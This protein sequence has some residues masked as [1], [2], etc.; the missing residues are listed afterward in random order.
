MG[1]NP[2]L[3]SQLLNELYSGESP[4]A[5]RAPAGTASHT[6]I[7]KGRGA[8]RWTRH[9]PGYTVVRTR[10]RPPHRVAAAT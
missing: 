2:T 9:A 3:D 1:A 4:P 5:P 6:E 7:A 10:K 8:P